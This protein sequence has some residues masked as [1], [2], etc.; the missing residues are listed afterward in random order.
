[1]LKVKQRNISRLLH[2][3][4]Y[5]VLVLII[6]WMLGGGLTEVVF[7]YTISLL[8]A[9]V[10]T[11]FAFTRDI[12][13]MGRLRTDLIKPFVIYG[14]QVYLVFVF[15]YLNH[16]FDIIL[17]KHYLTA[18]DVSF[19]QIPVNI[20]ERLW[21]IPNAM[22]SILFPTLL[23]MQ[24][25]SGLFTAKICR[26][27]FILM[28]ILGGMITVLAPIFVPILYGEAYLPMVPALYSVIWG[29]VI[30]PIATFLGVYFASRKQISR[31]ILASGIGFLTNIVLNIILIPRIGI[32]GAGIATSISNTIWALI[33]A[34]FFIRQEK[35]GLR[36][37]FIIN[38][39]D[40]N[41]LR[42]KISGSRNSERS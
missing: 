42:E 39:S 31:N 18:S 23:A 21:Q 30:S 24:K 41:E 3:S 33:L 17:I 8:L 10:L 19:Y 29:I 32:V 6:V 38:G 16:R 34:I 36:G 14:F 22:S 11:L 1:M 2:N 9:A 15:N 28:F 5:F 26:V 12:R 13:P 7:A 40:I 25:G 35:S 27:N 20:C 37:I 4:L